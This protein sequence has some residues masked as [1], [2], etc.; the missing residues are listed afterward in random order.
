MLTALE[1]INEVS[2]E[3]AILALISWN[4]PPL[5]DEDFQSKLR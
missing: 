5:L 1:D 2:R 3:D 4:C